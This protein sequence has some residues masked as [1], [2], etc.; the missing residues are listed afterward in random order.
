MEE[1]KPIFPI[2]VPSSSGAGGVSPRVSIIQDAAAVNAEPFEFVVLPRAMPAAAETGEAAEAFKSGLQEMARSFDKACHGMSMQAQS[3]NLALA[4]T[5][6]T[7]FEVTLAHWQDLTTAKSPSEVYTLQLAYFGRQ[8]GLIW[9]QT[10]ELQV[11]FRKMM[12]HS[13]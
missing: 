10:Q 6:R 11:A 13:L 12:R 8:M 3:I 1:Q 9:S 2:A 7:N 4:E 5:L